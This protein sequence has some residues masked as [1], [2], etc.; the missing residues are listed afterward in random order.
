MEDTKLIKIMH[1]SG[2]TDKQIDKL[3]ARY[4]TL[5]YCAVDE[6]AALAQGNICPCIRSFNYRDRHPESGP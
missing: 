4:K 5:L 1:E 3:T 6:A 2:F